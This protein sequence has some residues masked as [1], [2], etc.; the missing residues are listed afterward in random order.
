MDAPSS[1]AFSSRSRATPAGVLCFWAATSHMCMTVAL[2][3]APASTLAPLHY[4]EIVTAVLLGYLV[5]GD[6]P[7]PLTWAGIAVIVSSGLYII[8]RERINAATI[9]AARQ[10]KPAAAG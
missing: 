3:Y 4:L 8:H 6:F 10:A 5:F 2:K 7:D 9:R 1:S